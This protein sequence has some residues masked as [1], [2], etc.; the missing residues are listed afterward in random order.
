MWQFFSTESDPS[1]T[2]RE[3]PTRG[4]PVLVQ[5]LVVIYPGQ[6]I[7]CERQRGVVDCNAQ[8]FG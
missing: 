6:L 3:S 1:I 4:T 2:V 7:G 8:G 5:T